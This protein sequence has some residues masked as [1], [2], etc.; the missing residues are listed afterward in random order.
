MGQLVYL[1]L[2]V[3]RQPSRGC[4]FCGALCDVN[5]E[6]VLIFALLFKTWTFIF[7][8]CFVVVVVVV[9]ESVTEYLLYHYYYYY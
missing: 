1:R 9:S 2:L 8:V 7:V 4:R 6:C 3:I 5:L